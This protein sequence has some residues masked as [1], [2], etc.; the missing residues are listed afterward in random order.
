[1]KSFITF[2]I[3]FFLLFSISWVSAVESEIENLPI[4]E[5]EIKEE[6]I[7]TE[8]LE[9]FIA[10]YNIPVPESISINSE[11]SLDISSFDSELREISWW[12]TNYRYTWDVFNEGSFEWINTTIGFD[13]YWKKS[14]SLWV[15]EVNNEEENEDILIARKDFSIFAFKSTLPV[16]VSSELSSEEVS[17]FEESA[18]NVW[19]YIYKIG[20]LS[21]SELQSTNLYSS[22]QEYQSELSPTSDYLVIWWEKEFLLSSL[23]KISREENE[24][25][26]KNFV[27]VSWY[28]GQILQNFLWNSL[29]G[30]DF[31]NKAFIIDDS[32]TNRLLRSPLGID[33]LETDLRVNNY[34]Y[35]S[36]SEK[37]QISP[38]LFI[39]SFISSLSETW[40]T[41]SQLYIILL[42]PIFLTVVAISK[43][44]IW[45]SP[46]GTIIPVFIAILYI[47]IGVI[48]TTILLITIIIVN[49]LLSNLVSKYTLLYTPKVTFLTIINLVIFI[50]FYN[51]A[52]TNWY[53][54]LSSESI[55]S[56][57][58]F[59]IVAERLITLIT[60]KELREYKKS[61]YGTLLVS[62]FC[63]FLYYTDFL[64]IFLTAYPEVLLILI[65]FNFF[66]WRFTG[67]RVS[68]YFR[69]RE[70]Y[71]N[72][73]E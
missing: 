51:F 23:S 21:E 26:M 5:E 2:S 36:I 13:S 43:H 35:F 55:F 42:L 8:N 17:D 37:I 67:L 7:Q 9:N 53:I 61:L 62:I 18:T 54:Q 19:I 45:I 31:I 28:N 10:S 29:A 46:I 32:M 15:Y 4:I 14:I 73:E 60:S 69:F 27:L 1:M 33:A 72:I 12:E 63:V 68:E 58:I 57:I 56:I 47:Q 41:T 59:F 52:Y 66:L 24:S 34:D 70:V 25:T 38:Y 40:I 48:F 22:Y 39:S 65:P 20:V 64:L 16:L 50:I 6:L 3:S 71:K 11:L 30:K 49:I 44:L